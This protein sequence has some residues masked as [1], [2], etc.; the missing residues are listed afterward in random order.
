[1]YVD[2]DSIYVVNDDEAREHCRQAGKPAPVTQFGRAMAELA[3]TIIAAHSPQAKGRVERVNRTLQD[4][5]LKEL[6]LAGLHDLAAANAFLAQGFL[7]AFNR[8]FSQ[9]PAPRD[10]SQ[11]G[12]AQGGAVH[13]Q[14][15]HGP[16]LGQRAP[17]QM[18]SP[19]P[20]HGRSL[21]AD[22]GYTRTTPPPTG[23]ME[24][25]LDQPAQ[26]LFAFRRQTR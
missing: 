25:S 22:R 14:Q 2:H 5:L 3:V 13:H 24:G 20:D 16:T 10:K 1:L 6:A 4:R 21:C 7:T 18:E 17:G 11:R 23:M 26:G 9:V 19:R 12:Q 15:A 8:R